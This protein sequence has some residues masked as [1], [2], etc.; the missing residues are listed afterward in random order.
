MIRPEYRD[1]LIEQRL[2]NKYWGGSAARNA[3]DHVCRFLEKRKDII[4]VLD[5]GC[6][7]GTLNEYV[8]KNCSRD[9]LQWHEYDPSV[10]GKDSEPTSMFDC[11][12]TTD[13]LEHVEPESLDSTLDWIREH[14]IRSQFH[15]IDFNDCKDTLLDGRSVHLI[16]EDLAW[17]ERQLC[18]PGWT[19]MYSSNIHQRK[20]GRIRSSGT[21]ILDRG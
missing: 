5:F 13:V 14:A 16:V 10:P 3:G 7:I 1:M 9:N 6:G 11:I 8:A 4:T 20:R 19:E 12:I 17:W 2:R 21:I 15:H 18:I